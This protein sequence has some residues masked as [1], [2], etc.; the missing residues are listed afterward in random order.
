MTIPTPHGAITIRPTTADDAQPLRA[1]RHEAML[2]SPTLFGSSVEDVD[3]HDWTKVAAGGAGEAVFIAEHAGQLVGMTGIHRSTGRKNHHHADIWGV[4]VQPAWRKRGIAQALVN[5][6]VDW[7]AG[8]G[9][10]IVKLTVVPESGAMA[11]YLHCG[12]RVTGVD[13]A[14]IYWNGRYYDELLMHRWVKPNALDRV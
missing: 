2:G 6:C 8:A 4:Y 11:C 1:L 10:A 12:F 7:A 9:V 5:R 3:S 13:P 14:A